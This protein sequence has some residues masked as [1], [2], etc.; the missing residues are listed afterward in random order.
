MLY[1]QIACVPVSSTTMEG[2]R[3]PHAVSL[4]V[5]R[6]SKPLLSQSFPLTVPDESSPYHLNT[7]KALD[8]ADSQFDRDFILSPVMTLP[9]AFGAAYVGE[10]F[11]CTLCANNELTAGV[12]RHVSNIKIGGEMQAPSGN[13]VLELSPKDEG[14][15][16]PTIAPGHSLQKIVRFDLREE[17]NH[18]LAINISY[19]E[20]TTAKD[21]SA[22]SGRF[23][24]FRKLYQFLARPCLN[25]RT[26]ISP[27]AIEDGQEVRTLVLEA[28]LDNVADGPVTLKTVTFTTKPAFKSTSLNWESIP[29]PAI[30]S[31]CPVLSPTDVMQVAFLIQQQEEG[32]TR[33]L[34]RDGRI[35]LGQLSIQWR[36]AMGDA[37][38]L[39]TGWLTTKRR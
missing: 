16:N 28:Q 31:M 36:T 6:L 27:M 24:S 9:P 37:G 8:T 15:N 26:K 12:D 3:E 19:T 2:V 34:T 17:G 30:G 10:T 7:P 35:I 23:R 39:S 38:F 22:S 18:T 25:V 13:F 20:T 32:P 11:S 1:I 21:N 29:N 14:E 5:L 33:E 4:K